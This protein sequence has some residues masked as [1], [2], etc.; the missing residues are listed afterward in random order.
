MPLCSD[1]PEPGQPTEA[2]PSPLGPF[3]PAGTLT[4]L[5]T[6]SVWLILGPLGSAEWGSG[7]HREIWG[8]P[9]NGTLEH[10]KD[11]REGDGGL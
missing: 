10:R 8:P 4:I 7:Y 11:A 9:V 2:T 3:V 1:L 5:V 6:S